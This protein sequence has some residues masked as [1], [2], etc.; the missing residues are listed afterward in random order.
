MSYCQ[1]LLQVRFGQHPKFVVD[2]AS[3]HARSSKLCHEVC[4]LSNVRLL[5]QTAD[6]TS[7]QAVE[8]NL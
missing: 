3:V 4:M 8:R 2:V 7:C 1:E 5:Q 6:F